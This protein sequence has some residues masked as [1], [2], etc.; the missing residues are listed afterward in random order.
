M[1]LIVDK[2]YIQNI[3]IEN[4]A[5]VTFTKKDGTSRV[6]KCTLD[7]EILPQK[8]PLPIPEIV[9]HDDFLV[10]GH[11]LFPKMNSR[12]IPLPNIEESANF[13]E[14]MFK[15]SDPKSNPPRNDNPNVVN[16]WDIENN[17]WKSFRLDSITN[18]EI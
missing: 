5:V 15:A 11:A 3:L 16:V 10:I 9:E 2:E 6:M 14:E 1:T 17:A 18:F 13:S 7:P 4:I 12:K 8:L